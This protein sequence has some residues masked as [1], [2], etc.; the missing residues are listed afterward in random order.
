MQFNNY[1]FILYFVPIVIVMYFGAN[2][3]K[4]TYGKMVLVAASIIFY[5]WGRI[6]YLPYLGISILISY[7]LVFI[8]RQFK[9]KSKVFMAIPIIINVGLLVYFKYWNF[10]NLNFSWITN[11]EFVAQNIVLPLGI[12]CYTF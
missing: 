5:A 9:L 2:K 8:S 3:L 11:R 7:G 12:S 1:S 10:I 6:N 4:T